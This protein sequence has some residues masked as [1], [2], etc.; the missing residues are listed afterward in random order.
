MA[1]SMSNEDDD[2]EVRIQAAIDHFGEVPEHHM[3]VLLIAH[4]RMLTVF[5]RMVDMAEDE[6]LQAMRAYFRSWPDDKID[7]LKSGL[8]DIRSIN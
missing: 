4:M 7:E 3:N 2:Q 6:F 1:A 5:A 8:V